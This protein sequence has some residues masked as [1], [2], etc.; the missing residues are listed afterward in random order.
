[1]SSSSVTSEASIGLFRPCLIVSS[2]VLQVVFVNLF[3]NSALHLSSHCCSFLLHVVAKLICIILSYT[4]TGSIFISFKISSFLLWSKRVHPDISLKNF[5]SMDANLILTFFFL[6]VKISLRL[7]K[8]GRASALYT[9]ILE[10]VWTK[11]SLRALLKFLLFE[12][13]LLVSVQ[14][15]VQFHRK[16]RDRVI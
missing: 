14:N 4:L 12:N 13:I 11:V 8:L 15:L 6:R 7:K 3:C 10:N 5:I 2:K 16:F 9:F 1:M